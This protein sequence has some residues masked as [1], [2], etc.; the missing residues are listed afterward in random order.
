MT[1]E[2]TELPRLQDGKMQSLQ[3]ADRR[4]LNNCVAFSS[5]GQGTSHRCS[6]RFVLATTGRG[7]K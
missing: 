3:V 7:G 5:T 2:I 4:V 1:W 6:S